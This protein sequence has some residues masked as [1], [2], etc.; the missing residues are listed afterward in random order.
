MEKF[1]A[2]NSPYCCLWPFAVK[3]P[4]L[5][6]VARTRSRAEA[7]AA[8]RAVSDPLSRAKLASQLITESQHTEAELT[9][10]RRQAI[11]EAVDSGISAT[12]IADEL[13][14]SKG[15]ISQIRS[16]G[17]ALERI[18]FGVGPITIGLPLRP[19]ASRALPVIATEDAIAR[20]ELVKVLDKLNFTVTQEDIDPRKAWRPGAPDLVAICGPKSSPTI[21]AVLAK[22]S[23]LRFTL[24]EAEHWGIDDIGAGRRYG[25]PM[26][27]PEPKLSDVA[28][29]GRL[30]FDSDRTV[31]IVAGVH[32]IGSLGA[33]HYLRSNLASLYA[34]VGDKNFSVVITSDHDAE[35]T[36]LRSEL[37][38]PP[39]IH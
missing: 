27:D 38:C 21:A 23:H 6:L 20:D 24:D 39:A 17:P 2:L 18:M 10:L 13:N 26:D 35:G 9:R 36:I 8:V 30:P 37:A 22:D 29:V 14:L 5:F 34:K 1:R 28:Y 7:I 16:G 25:S 19:I 11:D 31:F 33:V 4:K 32:A 15:R 12:T 3:G